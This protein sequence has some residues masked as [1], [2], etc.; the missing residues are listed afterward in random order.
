M[1]A[2]KRTFTKIKMRDHSKEEMSIEYNLVTLKICLYSYV[3]ETS[4]RERCIGESMI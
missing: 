1:M 2:I 4:S 3:A